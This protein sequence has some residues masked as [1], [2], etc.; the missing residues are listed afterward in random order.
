[1]KTTLEKCLEILKFKIVVRMVKPTY[2]YWDG[3][4]KQEFEFTPTVKHYSGSDKPN[5]KWGSWEANCWFRNEVGA[6]AAT[7]LANMRRKLMKGQGDRIVTIE[8][9]S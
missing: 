6:T 1:M 4:A 2:G 5:I 9:V 3:G 7:H 8:L